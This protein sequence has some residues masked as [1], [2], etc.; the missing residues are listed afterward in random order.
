MTIAVNWKF[1]RR[2]AQ[3]F[4][5]LPILTVSATADAAD[6]KFQAVS[7]PKDAISAESRIHPAN[8]LGDSRK[9]IIVANPDSFDVFAFTD[10]GYAL[11]Q[12]VPVTRLGGGPVGKVYYGFA[13]LEPGDRYTILVM[14]PEGIGYYPLTH[15]QAIGEP[16]LLFSRPMIQGQS[17][18]KPTQYF[19]FAVDLDNDGL[20]DLLLPEQDG[21]SILKQVEPKK[22]APVELPR[23]PYKREKDF[24]FRQNNSAGPAWAESYSGYVRNRRGVNDLLI[25]D[26]NSD[27]L[28]DLIFT[29]FGPGPDSSQVER[30]DVFLQRKGMSFAAEPDQSIL[31][32]HD[33]RADITFRDLN[34]DGHLDVVSVQS[35]IDIANP[36]TVTRLYLTNG[37]KEQMLSQASQRFITKDPVGLI[38]IGDFNSDGFPDFATTYFSY[39]FSS[40]D[41][42]V[43]LALA[44][45]IRFKLQFF[46]GRNGSVNQ[47]QPDG[48]KELTLH[49]KAESLEGTPPFLMVPD[50][51][52][53]RASDLV[54]RTRTDE[55]SVY[56]SSGP[57]TFPSSPAATLSVPDDA[58]VD[59]E[60]LNGDGLGD[61]L[62]SSPSRKSFTAY[63]STR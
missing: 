19:D 62:V 33:P 31:V 22:F 50:M 47:R 61:L 30:Y 56:P 59:T 3:L 54:V 7:L 35:N 58:S 20:E 46:L 49:V 21:F 55:L 2:A 15:E 37:K 60:D 9:E 25:F 24:R 4:C 28:Q 36:R 17:G 38:N 45:R 53:D 48:E 42:I 32:P 29:E 6:L 57:V 1:L 18:G 14:T 34:R 51:N 52:G 16:R 41:D 27:T 40:V 11:V 10:S 26:A 44:S 23:N 13:R 43:D 39:Q 8:L 12:T 63:I 5:L